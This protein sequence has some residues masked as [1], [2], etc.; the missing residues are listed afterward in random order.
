MPSTDPWAANFEDYEGFLEP[1]PGDTG[2][3]D[4]GEFDFAFYRQYAAKN[5]HKHGVSS[6]EIREVFANEPKRRLV[7][8][9][10]VP[11][12]E[13]YFALGRTDAGRLLVVFYINKGGGLVMPISAYTMPRRMRKQY[14]RK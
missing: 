14:E 11:G 13:K 7:E 3:T 8:R 2:D 5:A 4:E 10:H 1:E 9:G 6:E 12:E